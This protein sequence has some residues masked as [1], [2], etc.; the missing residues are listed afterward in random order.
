MPS[1]IRPCHNGR[2]SKEQS[3]AQEAVPKEW[4]SCL[5][6][7]VF[8]VVSFLGSSDSCPK[9]V[10]MCRRIILFRE[11]KLSTLGQ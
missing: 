2:Y 7:G 11:E 5:E 10:M 1:K 3:L 4:Q 9:V 8:L 6:E